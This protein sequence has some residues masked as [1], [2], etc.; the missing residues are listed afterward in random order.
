MIGYSLGESGCAYAD[1]CFTIEETILAAYY[2]GVAFAECEKNLIHGTM[3]AVGM[4][5]SVIAS[6]FFIINL[7]Y[8]STSCMK[9]FMLFNK[10]F[11]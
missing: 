3:A 10:K 2:R 1:G 9:C 11:F 8:N 4:W 7:N 5:Y 6:Y